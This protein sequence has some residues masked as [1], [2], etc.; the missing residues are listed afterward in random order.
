MTSQLT[1]SGGSE[2]VPEAFR[3]IGP[4]SFLPPPVYTGEEGRRSGYGT[5]KKFKPLNLSDS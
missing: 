5:K 1:G 3:R 4:T 2:G